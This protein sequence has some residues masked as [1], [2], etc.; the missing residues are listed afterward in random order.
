[1]SRQ[2]D[3]KLDGCI[4]TVQSWETVSGYMMVRYLKGD[5]W[6]MMEY[7][8]T[9]FPGD[10]DVHHERACNE[11]GCARAVMRYREAQARLAE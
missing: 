11:Q 5:P 1:M 4:V 2:T 9:D 6:V 8:E 10:L 3:V 7:C